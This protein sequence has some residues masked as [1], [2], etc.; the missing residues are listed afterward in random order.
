MNSRFY[1]GSNISY[2][3]Y[4]KRKMRK[5]FRENRQHARHESIPS[6]AIE[7]RLILISK[8]LKFLQFFNRTISHSHS[9]YTQFLLK[10]L[11]EYNEKMLTKFEYLFGL[12]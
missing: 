7:L 4:L 11:E 1:I 12:Y 2:V 3:L 9:K 6:L 8:F 5:K 10:M